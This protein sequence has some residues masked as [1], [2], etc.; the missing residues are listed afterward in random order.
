M[1]KNI[2]I[3]LFVLTISIIFSACNSIVDSITDG[4]LDK[5]EL[6]IAIEN[7]KVL[8]PSK[9]IGTDI[10]NVSQDSYDSY[11]A[12]ISQAE[13]IYSKGDIT[14]TQLS[15]AISDLALAT[16]TFKNS[17]IGSDNVKYLYATD[18]TSDIISTIGA[19]EYSTIDPAY[20][21]DSAYNPCLKVTREAWNVKLKFSGIELGTFSNYATLEFKIKANHPKVK[22]IFDNKV[23]GT[24]DDSN[25]TSTDLIDFATTGT[26]LGNDWYSVSIDLSTLDSTKLS[27]ATNLTICLDDFGDNAATLYIT[28]ICLKK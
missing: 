6:N 4:H 1:K 27:E 7:A 19:W 2:L 11:A 28:D 15:T 23:D 8:L 17:V 24:E 20:A 14:K 5:S 22:A 18:G 12:S 10:G 16:T 13:S 21:L 26:S 25:A 3:S 9:T